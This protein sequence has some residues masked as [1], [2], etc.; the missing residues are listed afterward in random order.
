MHETHVIRKEDLLE[1][2]SRFDEKSH[3]MVQA[4]GQSLYVDSASYSCGKIFINCHNDIEDE[5]EDL[6]EEITNL[7]A[8]LKAAGRNI[9]FLI[10]RLR[11][12]DDK[13]TNSTEKTIA[14]L[15]EIK[16]AIPA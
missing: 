16:E 7:K 13:D 4:G 1:M 9:G 14:E 6:E 11:M 2:L 15:S 12:R 8:A 5:R 10:H 3:I